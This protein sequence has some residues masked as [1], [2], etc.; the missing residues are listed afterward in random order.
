MSNSED[1]TAKN[2]GNHETRDMDETHETK[3]IPFVM[4]WRS[5]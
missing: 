3:P 5:W 2:T 1:L 4:S